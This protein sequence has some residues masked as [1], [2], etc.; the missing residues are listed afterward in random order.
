MNFKKLIPVLVIITAIALAYIYDL[1]HLIT[2]Q[3]LQERKEDLREFVDH[4]AVFA[5]FLYIAAYIVT[6]SLSLPFASLMTL[7]GG[8]LF[9][10]WAGTLYVAIGATIG[11]V[12]IF[13]ITR[14]A[15]GDTLR[16][17]AG[18]LYKK[19]EPE[20][21][22]NAFSYLLF[23][24]LVPLFPFFLVNIVPALFPISLRAFLIATFIGILPGTFV[25]VNLGQTLGD[26]ESLSGL[27]SWQTLGAFVLLGIFAMIPTFYKKFISSKKKPKS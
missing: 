12:I 11:A 23:L 16:A 6:V 26:I 21:R 15:F 14:S 20:M 5:P 2:L 1:H 19:I 13:L 8:F 24:R 22:E 27:V 25:Y 9:G 10:L 17:K 18:R 7:L 3:N 4:H